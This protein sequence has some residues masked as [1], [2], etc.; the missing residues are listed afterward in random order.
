MQ[1]HLSGSTDEPLIVV[2][3][4]MKTHKFRATYSIRSCWYQTKLWINEDLSQSSDFKNKLIASEVLQLIGKT[5]KGL[6]EELIGDADI[7]YPIELDVLI[8]KKLMFK[9]AFLDCEQSY[10]EDKLIENSISDCGSSQIEDLIDLTGKLYP[11][12]DKHVGVRL[13]HENDERLKSNYPNTSY[14]KL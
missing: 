10:D 9:E 2:L 3:Q 4:L 7:G 11:N 14:A 5:A 6:K 12:S 8:E 13:T 1:S